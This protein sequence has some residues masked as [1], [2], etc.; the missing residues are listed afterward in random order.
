MN[1]MSNSR[2]RKLSMLGQKKSIVMLPSSGKFEILGRSV[3][4]FDFF[5]LYRS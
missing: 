5:L 2:L 1:K 3:G 4:F